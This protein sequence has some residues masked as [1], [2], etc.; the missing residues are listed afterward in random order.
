MII[1]MF[2]EIITK[3]EVKFNNLA[4]FSQSLL[5]IDSFYDNILLEE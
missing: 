4:F 1:S 2:E 5:E 3:D